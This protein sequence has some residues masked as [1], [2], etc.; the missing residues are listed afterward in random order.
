MSS[1][2]H[3][4]PRCAAPVEA[5]EVGLSR[6]KFCGNEVDLG[7]DAVLRHYDSALREVPG[8]VPGA[9]PAT[10]GPPLHAR[11]SPLAASAEPTS[12]LRGRLKVLAGPLLALTAGFVGAQS[13]F[14]FARNGRDP[15]VIF[16]SVLAGALALSLLASA[17]RAAAAAVTGFAG[18]LFAAKPFARP[19]YMKDGGLFGPTSE[20]H[21]YYLIPGGI[22][23]MIA[24][25]IALI[26]VSARE[27]KDQPPEPSAASLALG[28]AGLAAGIALATHFFSGETI[29]E[30]IDRYR[31]RFA[32]VRD[33]WAAIHAK[34]PPPG[35]PAADFTRTDLSPRPI[36]DKK[37]WQR[38]N[39][40]VLAAEQLLDPDGKPSYDLITSNYLHTS[41]LWTG[42]K[43]PMSET[44]LY[45]RSDD[46]AERLERVLSYRYLAVYRPSG[47]SDRGAGVEA[48]E[49]LE[50]FVFD[51]TTTELVASFKA[52]RPGY[53]TAD[54]EALAR[55]LARA[56]GGV[57]DLD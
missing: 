53:F 48:T 50:V 14:V 55:A 25:I 17:R 44:V 12:P 42:P 13:V 39:T 43:N 38:S 51:L 36:A 52:P 34:L 47:A 23:L 26:V 28:A 41:V 4:C 19:I 1:R 57:F 27:L 30:A 11:R 20:T 10:P 49:G 3:P 8:E 15:S 5:A 45:E 56:T 9:P 35:S 46:F 40:E 7:S 54:R 22:L 32:A 18:L 31:P 2:V 16:T 6:C 21:L 29:A 33:T 37:N 24:A